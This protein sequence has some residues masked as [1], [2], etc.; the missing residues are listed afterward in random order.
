V[1]LAVLRGCQIAQGVVGTLLVVFDH[2]TVSRL[3]DVVEAGEQVLVQNL[4]SE[5]PLEAFDVGVLV[6]LA[7]LDVANCHCVGPAHWM[8]VSPRN[9]GPLS[10]RRKK[11]SETISV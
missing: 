5:G 6:R 9:S 3:A 1:A 4:L 11:G 7:G 10:V 8:N 2:P